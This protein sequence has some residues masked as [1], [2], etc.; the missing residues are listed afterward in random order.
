MTDRESISFFWF[1]RDLRLED[2][3]GF[4]RALTSDHPVVCGFIF[5]SEILDDLEDE[6]DGRIQFI[7]QE[8]GRLRNELRQHGSDLVVNYGRPVDV[9]RKWIEE[10]SIDQVH[11]NRDYEPYARLRDHTIES[12]LKANGIS[13]HTHKDQII[14]D[15]D[16]VV[17]D[18][19]KPYTVYTPYSKK[20]RRR[21]T[22]ADLRSFHTEPLFDRLHPFEA[23]DLPGL[24]EMGF[25]SFPSQ[26]PARTIDKNLLKRYAE[27]RDFPAQNGTSQLGIHLRFGTIS[28]RTLSRAAIKYSESFLNELIWRNFYQDVLWHFPQSTTEALKPKYDQIRWRNNA[29]EFEI[30]KEGR[31]GYPLVD[32]GMRQLAATGYMHNRIRMVTASFLAKH[33]LIDWRW[34]EAWFARKLLDFDLASNVGGWQWAAGSGADAAPYFRIFNPRLQTEK[35]DPDGLYVR[36]WVPELGSAAYPPP[37]IDHREARKRALE[38]YKNAVGS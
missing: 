6:C 30:W 10:F 16:E 32:A 5:D 28:I 13:F 22:V 8:L 34:G 12:L 38:V 20:W 11:A 29:E 33:L 27:K 18:D 25:I 4:Y 37:M 31:T 19:G 35:F 24:K 17:K 9:W 15:R 3:V 2:N 7:H 23:N 26:Y 36:R 1:R 14:F 21:L